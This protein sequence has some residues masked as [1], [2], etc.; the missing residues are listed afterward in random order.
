MRFTLHSF[1]GRASRFAAAVLLGTTLLAACDEDRPTEPVP[2]A[3]APT[4]PS[5]A[6]YLNTGTLIWKAVDI[7]AKLL[8]GATFQ[9]NGGPG[10]IQWV[11]PDNN[12]GDVDMIP[13]QF[14][15]GGVTPGVYQVCEIIPPKGYLKPWNVCKSLVVNAGVITDYGTFVSDELAW[16]T[17][18]YV[19]YA[20]TP[21]G[22]GTYSVTDTLGIKIMSIVDNSALDVDPANGKFKFQLPYVGKFTVCEEKA[23]PGWYFPAGQASLCK[24][25]A[26][27]VNTTAALGD[28]MVV[29][30]Y[31]AVWS[32]ISGWWGPLNK[33]P[34][35]LGPSIYTVTKTD[36][37][38]TWTFADN[39]PSDLHN[40]LG[41]YYVK[42]PSAGTYNV[43]Q[44]V[45]IPGY[46]LP[47]PVCHQVD[48]AFAKVGWGD[49]FL[50]QEKQ[51]VYTP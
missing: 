25:A 26:G 30:P 48:V 11:M 18:G 8:G 37:S 42:L 36:N 17:T 27:N 3:A 15:F 23:P 31:S 10:Q 16:V 14:K 12:A 5:D 34:L 9:I 47:D 40:M 51:V 22:G 29:P 49:F 46:F 43:C 24:Y 35:W 1:D 33:S 45:E 32:V 2:T 39:S 41:I 7:N 50:N 28:N 6:R 20:K 44:A 13:G 19:D 38:W 21:V 4:K